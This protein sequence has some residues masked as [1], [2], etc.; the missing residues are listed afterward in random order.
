[1]PSR[2][3]LAPLNTGKPPTAEDVNLLYRLIN[4]Y[5]DSRKG[6]GMPVRLTAFDGRMSTGLVDTTSYAL[7]VR[8]RETTTQR[9]AAFRR[10]DNLVVAEVVGGRLRAIDTN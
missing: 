2:N 3:I 1:M 8:N 4:G 9:T 5:Y 10:A 6:H 7:D